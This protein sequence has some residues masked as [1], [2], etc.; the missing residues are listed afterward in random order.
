MSFKKI[1]TEAQQIILYSNDLSQS[2]FLRLLEKEELKT[3]SKEHL[4]IFYLNNIEK[5]KNLCEKLKQEGIQ[6]LRAKE[7]KARG[8]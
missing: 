2:L 1:Y 5:F 3:L 7:C 4:V 8:E 6:T